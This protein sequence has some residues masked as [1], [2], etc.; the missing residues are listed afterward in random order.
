MEEAQQM[1]RHADISTT[2]RY[3]HHID[4]MRQASEYLVSSYLDND[5]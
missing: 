4:R 2:M 1:A 3:A 5:L